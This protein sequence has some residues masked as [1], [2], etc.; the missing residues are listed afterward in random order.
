MMQAVVLDEAGAYRLEDRPEPVPGPGEVAIR[1][2]YAGV[3]WGD[4]LLRDGHFGVERPFVPGFEVAGSITRVGEGV[5][6]SRVGEKVVALLDGGGYAEVAVVAAARAVGVGG[7]P[8]RDAAALGWAAPTAYDLVAEVG[9]VREGE[10]VL[11]HAAAGGVGT[12]AVQFA[13][14]A[15]AGQVVGVVGGAERAA[16]AKGFGYDRLVLRGD[17]PAVVEEERFDVILDPVG[18]ATR[19]ANLGLLAPHGRLAVY[20]NIAGFEDVAVSANELLM[21]GL[22]VGAYNS[23]ALVHTRPERV[24][25]TMRKVLAG[26]ADGV[27]R[28]DV[29]AEVPLAG[30]GPAVAALAS[31]GGSLGRTLVRVA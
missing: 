17:F 7:L 24:A 19:T 28:V 1:V 10:R 12:Y 15:G 6:P 31:G 13:R 29:G 14:A 2:A 26:L 27:V 4:V 3:Q 18:A 25:R 23:S 20:G 22:T 5:E 8:L 11:V 30:V 16:Y 21:R 9:R